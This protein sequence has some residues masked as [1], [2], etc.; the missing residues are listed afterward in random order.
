[1]V[2]FHSYVKLPEAKSDRKWI[3]A[4]P[5]PRWVASLHIG[6]TGSDWH[7]MPGVAASASDTG[8]VRK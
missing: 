6:V 3:C 8:A 1:M 4:L 7:A 2:I 5:I